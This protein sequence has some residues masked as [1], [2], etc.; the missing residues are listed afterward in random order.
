VCGASRV[1]DIKVGGVLIL[2]CGMCLSGY[3]R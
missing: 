3:I 2:F 1:R